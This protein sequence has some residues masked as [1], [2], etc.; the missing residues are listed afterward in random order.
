MT[1]KHTGLSVHHIDKPHKGES[2]SYEDKKS[3]LWEWGRRLL[4]LAS[5][6]TT[7]HVGYLSM[8]GVYS[9][10]HAKP[11]VFGAQNL[12][13]LYRII[14]ALKPLDLGTEKIRKHLPTNSEAEFNLGMSKNKDARPLKSRR[15]LLFVLEKPRF[16][17]VNRYAGVRTIYR[18]LYSV[19]SRHADVRTT[20]RPLLSVVNRC[21]DVRTL[22]S[23]VTWRVGTRAR[24]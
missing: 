3:V 13:T 16:S 18:P 22:Y 5:V 11:A 8:C 9:S 23:V 21:A 19:V 2:S 14:S 10:R 15:C 20:D 6:N 1:P 24:R 7:H 4:V 17:L 12:G